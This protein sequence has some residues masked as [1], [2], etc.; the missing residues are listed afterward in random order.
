MCVCLWSP[1]PTLSSFMSAV[2][3]KTTQFERF[4]HLYAACAGS[5]ER[6]VA[7]RVTEGAE[8]RR[9]SPMT[10]APGYVWTKHN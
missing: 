3:V 9:R 5:V 2:K 8:S 4:L 7:E 10:A 6:F 1:S